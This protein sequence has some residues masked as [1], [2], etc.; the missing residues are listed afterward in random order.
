MFSLLSNGQD[1][2]EKAWSAG[3]SLPQAPL[4]VA[5]DTAG[6]DDWLITFM[7]TLSPVP[8]AISSAHS[9][10]VLVPY[11]HCAGL[12]HP[13]S[14]RTSQS[15]HHLV[16]EKPW[17]LCFHFPPQLSQGNNLHCAGLTWKGVWTVNIRVPVHRRVIIVTVTVNFNWLGSVLL[18]SCLTT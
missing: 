10:S 3:W 15:V 18:A 14:L 9:T 6:F 12:G 17:N 11:V 13:V 16:A 5:V 2:H 1:F 4:P 8:L 7:C